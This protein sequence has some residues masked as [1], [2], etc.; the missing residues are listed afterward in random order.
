MVCYCTLYFDWNVFDPTK[1]LSPPKYSCT[2][3]AYV[4]ALQMRETESYNQTDREEEE[5]EEEGK[6]K[7]DRGGGGGGKQIFI[8]LRLTLFKN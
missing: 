2:R 3:R 5:S 6:G 7:E 4:K 8:S 1:F